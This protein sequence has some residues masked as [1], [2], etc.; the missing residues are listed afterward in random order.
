MVNDRKLGLVMGK[1]GWQWRLCALSS[2]GWLSGWT[3][4]SS[5]HN[6]QDVQEEV[7]DVQVEVERSKGVVV[8]VE[9]ELVPTPWAQHQLRVEDDVEGKHPKWT[10]AGSEGGGRESRSPEVMAQ[11]PERIWHV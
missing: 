7:D 1:D 4:L 9:L 11:K 8:N 3:S 2:T 6:L 10:H 5:S